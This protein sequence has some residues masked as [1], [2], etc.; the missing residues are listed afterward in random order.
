MCYFR[1]SV[2][3]MTELL[4]FIADKLLVDSSQSCQV[5]YY[6]VVF[7]RERQVLDACSGIRSIE[8]VRPASIA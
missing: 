3:L 4:L 5:V 1:C 8:E 2:V 7:P 6:C